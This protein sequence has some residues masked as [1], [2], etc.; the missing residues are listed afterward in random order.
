MID[1]LLELRNVLPSLSIL[2]C[3]DAVFDTTKNKSVANVALTNFFMFD[4]C[5]SFL[6]YNSLFKMLGFLRL[7]WCSATV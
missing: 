1:E 4:L 7:C 3:A 6:K 2:H 5:F